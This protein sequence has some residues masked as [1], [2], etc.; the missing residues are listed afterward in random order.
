MK[1]NL[2]ILFTLSLLMTFTACSE[3]KVTSPDGAVTALITSEND[4]LLLNIF[5]KGA[6]AAQ[7]EVGG[8]VF[9]NE[10]YDFTGALKLQSTT[11][12]VISEAYTLPTG[13]VS[14]YENN[15][16]E[17]TLAYVNAAGKKMCLI[18]RAYN[19]GVAFRYAF[20]NSEELTVTKEVTALLLPPSS[21]VWAMEYR[22][23]SEGYYTKRTLSE[24][25]K[26]PYHMPALVETPKGHWMLIH[27]A[28]VLG[29]SAAS[30]LTPCAEGGKLALSSEQPS[31]DWSEEYMASNPWTFINID[32]TNTIVAAP[33][34]ATP[35]RMLIVGDTPGTIVE[36]TMAEN[37][38]PPASFE[39]TWITPGVAGFPWWGDNNANGD[40]KL[41][42]Q[43]IDMVETMTWNRSE[44]RRVGKECRSRWSP[45][46]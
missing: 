4:K 31:L 10:A 3:Q 8:L 32:D 27:E 39:Q 12:D 6:E 21:N 16:N 17:M 38:C 13:K 7:W 34:W 5:V 29:R 36:S 18:V 30:F 1:K 45:Y 2:L 24:M 9:D 35:W 46:H 14:A 26:P 25:N 23:D 44:E 37:L 43:Y 42:K 40:K 11:F 33:N 20:D 19:D 41:L 15:A 22:N 28:D